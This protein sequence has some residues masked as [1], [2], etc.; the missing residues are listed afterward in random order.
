MPRI[1]GADEY[2]DGEFP[3]DPVIAADEYRMRVAGFKEYVQPP[4]KYNKTA[5][6]RVLFRMEVLHQVDDA[7]ADVTDIDGNQL[8][9]DFTVPFFYDPKRTGIWQG[10]VAK[11]RKFLASALNVPVEEPIEFDDYDQLVGK[12]MIG[13]IIVSRNKDNDKVNRIESVRPA[14]KAKTAAPKKTVAETAKE[15]FPDAKVTEEDDDF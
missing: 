11:S 14:R 6:D 9:E 13:S 10:K 8:P 2:T 12:E 1:K 5:E 7:D 3:L 4:G 15:E